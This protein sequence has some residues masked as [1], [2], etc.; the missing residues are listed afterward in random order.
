MYDNYGGD[1]FIYCWVW[2][3]MVYVCGHI[4]IDLW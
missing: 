2:L 1:Y 4:I 3:M